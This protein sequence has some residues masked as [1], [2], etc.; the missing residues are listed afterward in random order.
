[1]EWQINKIC[2]NV[3]FTLTRLWP[4]MHQSRLTKNCWHRLSSPS[5]YIVMWSS[6]RLKVAFN[7]W[8]RYIYGV[9]RN[10]HISQYTNR[11]L[12]V[13]LD[14]YYSYRMCC[15]IFKLI[16]TGGP[17]YLFDRIQF[18]QSSR[19]FK[20]ITPEHRTA[21]RASSFF[22]QRA[23]MWNG[24]PSSVRRDNSVWEV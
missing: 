13:P 18:G 9:S 17:R 19:L 6:A 21:A 15:W 2:R 23:I 16:R 12:G 22:V 3:F 5:F 1:M 20:L 4:I 7:S 24:L 11:I 14:T 8:A 10:Q